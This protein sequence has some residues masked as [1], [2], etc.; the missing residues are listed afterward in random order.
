MMGSTAGDLVP[1][2]F[3]SLISVK[4]TCYFPGGWVFLFD[5]NTASPCA[6]F[7]LSIHKHGTRIM[8]SIARLRPLEKVLNLIL[9]DLNCILVFLHVIIYDIY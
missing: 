8:S 5:S 2:K 7:L 3:A 4:M 9:K 6:H 1:R